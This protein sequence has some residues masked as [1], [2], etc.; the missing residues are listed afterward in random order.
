MAF[1]VDETVHGTIDRDSS[2]QNRDIAQGEAAA[3]QDVLKPLDN[4]P[5]ALLLSTS[6]SGICGTP[7]TGETV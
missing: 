2:F 4:N 6:G 5:I 3:H 1:L 7:N